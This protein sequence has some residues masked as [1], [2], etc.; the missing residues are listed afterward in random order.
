MDPVYL[1]LS[2]PP[3]FRSVNWCR[4][5]GR[6]I[7]PQ[8]ISPLKRANSVAGSKETPIRFSEMVPLE[9]KFSVTV[10]MEE[11]V[12]GERVPWKLMSSEMQ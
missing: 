12:S 5:F 1:E 3:G 7:I 9:N 2:V 6:C 11:E 4:E 8:V 10:G